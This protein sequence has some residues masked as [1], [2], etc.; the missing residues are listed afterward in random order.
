MNRKGMTLA[1]FLFVVGFNVIW[2]A[3]FWPIC[4]GLVD[5]NHPGIALMLQFAPILAASGWRALQDLMAAQ[6]SSSA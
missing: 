5:R 1:A 4:I 2:A 3:I 6:P